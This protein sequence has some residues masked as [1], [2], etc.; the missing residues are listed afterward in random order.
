MSSSVTNCRIHLVLHL[1]NATLDLQSPLLLQLLILSRVAPVHRTV[2]VTPLGLTLRLDL[3]EPLLQPPDPILDI[4]RS[5][6]LSTAGSHD[7]PSSIK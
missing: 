1:L 7:G 4:L 5:L 6:L 3:L 2:V